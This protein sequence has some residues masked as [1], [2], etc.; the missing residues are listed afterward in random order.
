MRVFAMFSLRT[1]VV[2]M[3]V[4][5]GLLIGIPTIASMFLPDGI[6]RIDPLIRGTVQVFYLLL[7]LAFGLSTVPV[8]VKVV[9]GAQKRIGNAD[10]PVV[11]AAIRHQNRIIWIMLAL[12]LLGAAIAIPAMILDGG[13][14]TAPARK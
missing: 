1:H 8:I 7:F 9:L 5:L 13:F 6:G 14:D 2:I 10:K 4:L 12:M 3:L 11:G